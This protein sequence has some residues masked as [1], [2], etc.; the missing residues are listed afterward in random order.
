M[1]LGA[2]CRPKEGDPCDLAP[3]GKALYRSPRRNRK[4]E[5][6]P[7]GPEEAC[8]MNENRSVRAWSVVALS[9]MTVVPLAAAC[10]GSSS[11]PPNTAAGTATMAMGQPPPGY[12]GA[13]PPGYPGAQP[14]YPGAQP[15]PAPQPGYPAPGQPAPQPA[16]SASQPPPGPLAQTDPNSL[17]G[18]LQGLQGALQGTVVTPGALGGDVAD[19]GLKAQAS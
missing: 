7:E 13:P 18:I 3:A 1:T 9:A 17:Q 2:H 5:S 11:P 8:A 6:V 12:P 4:T 15:G 19:I 16:P 10:G 14:A